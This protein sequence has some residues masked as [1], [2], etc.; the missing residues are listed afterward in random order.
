MDQS[1]QGVQFGS[2]ED[3]GTAKFPSQEQLRWTRSSSS[4]MAEQHRVT[5]ARRSGYVIP[6]TVRTPGLGRRVTRYKI[7][8]SSTSAPGSISKRARPD[9]RTARYY[10][11]TASGKLLVKG[12]V[13]YKL[14][15]SRLTRASPLTCRTTQKTPT[16]K[17]TTHKEVKVN[18]R[19]EK[20][21]LDASG[22]TLTRV[23]ETA[24]V[25]TN[26]TAGTQPGK[27]PS[28]PRGVSRVVICGVTY[29]RTAP[30][31]LVRSPAT[32]KVQEMAS[33]AVQRSILTSQTARYRKTNRQA[34]ARQYCMFYN[35]FGRCNRGN[36]CPYIHDPDK[37]AVCTSSKLAVSL[38]SYGSLY[39]TVAPAPPRSKLVVSQ[40]S[41]GSL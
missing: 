31:K 30:G 16:D 23:K 19:G 18:I 22:K 7:V 1:Q 14:S 9:P 17:P 20:F 36:D 28:V 41:Y 27:E 21:L 34:A 35:R 12:G 40:E 6:G 10:V 8:K 15:S 11:K 13:V 32:N 24:G 38:E 3:T 25:S 39:E 26:E 2:S 37:V 29:I 33:R 5:D 4:V